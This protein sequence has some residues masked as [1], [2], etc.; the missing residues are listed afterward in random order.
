MIRRPPQPAGGGVVDEGNRERIGL[1]TGAGSGMGAACARRLAAEHRAVVL[2]DVRPGSLEQV[3]EDVEL[4]GA[5]AV[6]VAG[7]VTDPAD[8]GRAVDGALT[9]FGRLD[10][11]VNAAGVLEPTRF[12]D[13]PA[14]EWAR[15]VEVNLTGAFLVTQAAAR[16]MRDRGW[17]RIVHFSSTA[18]KTVS[19]LGGAHYTASKHGVLG[20]VRAAAKELAA[21]GITV[22]AV[23]PGLIDTEMVRGATT[24]EQRAAYA[25][26]FPIPRL[27][28]PEEVADIVAFLA[29]EAAAYITGAAVDVNG[30]DLMV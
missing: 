5:G 16:P 20:L 26:S 28:S 4:V 21:F 23:C 1:V 15:V 18:G 22:N 24:Q 12:L 29:S 13:I 17:G 11:L 2:F 3:A 10:V 19:T 7:D 30:G 25:A 27:G 9:G 6:V 8:V 14:G